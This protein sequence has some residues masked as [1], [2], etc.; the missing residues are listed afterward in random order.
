MVK[1]GKKPW[2]VLGNKG[3]KRKEHRKRSEEKGQRVEKDFIYLL[4]YSQLDFLEVTF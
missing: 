1:P 4:S 2:V 3:E